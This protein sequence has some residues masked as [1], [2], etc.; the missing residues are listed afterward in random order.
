MTAKL[1][2]VRC[3]IV[4][5]FLQHWALKHLPLEFVACNKNSWDPHPI[6][7]TKAEVGAKS[8]TLVESDRGPVISTHMNTL[9]CQ[10]HLDKRYKETLVVIDNFIHHVLTLI[11]EQGKV[12]ITL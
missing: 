5:Q 6:N 3:R 9:A 8:T 4:K 2:E 12:D 10:F 7:L 11:Q 1:T